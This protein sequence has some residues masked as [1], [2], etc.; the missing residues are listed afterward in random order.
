MDKI[1][2]AVMSIFITYQAIEIQASTWRSLR[3]LTSLNGKVCQDVEI[4]YSETV[5]SGLHCILRCVNHVT[6]ESLFYVPGTKTCTGCTVSYDFLNYPTGQIPGSLY[7][8]YSSSSG[9][10]YF[11]SGNLQTFLNP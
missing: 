7:Y 9:R 4:A 11:S 10:F 8:I 2:L 1:V 3:A 5:R 6:C